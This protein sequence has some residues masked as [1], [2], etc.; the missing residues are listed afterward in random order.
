VSWQ[1]LR[2]RALPVECVVFPAAP[3]DPDAGVLT[4]RVAALPPAVWEELVDAHPRRDD[5]PAEWVWDPR[6]LRPH[7]LAAA[8]TLDGQSITAEEWEELAREA[9]L[10]S[11]ELD[12]LFGVALQLNTRAHRL[13]LGKD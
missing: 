4:F 11:G 7:A 8:V 6:S 13:S 5:Q 10:S 2:G 3:T 1:R 12:E 9:R